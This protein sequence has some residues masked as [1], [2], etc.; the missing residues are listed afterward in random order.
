M[1]DIGQNARL[2]RQT[3]CLIFLLFMI[4]VNVVAI[5]IFN[6]LGVIP[7]LWSPAF[8][9]IISLFTV[10]IPTIH[11]LVS[12]H[13]E[14]RGFSEKKANLIG[15][16]T[17]DTYIKETRIGGISLLFF[18]LIL[19]FVISTAPLILNGLNIASYLF[20][21]PCT[22]LALSPADSGA[23]RIY[24]DIPNGKCIGISDSTLTFDMK[25]E[26]ASLKRNASIDMK[27]GQADE[28][29]QLWEDAIKRNPDDAEALIYLEDYKVQ[30]RGGPYIALVVVASLTGDER[31]V[32]IGREILQGAYTAQK[33]YNN[34]HPDKP[35]FLYIANSG[36]SS[37][38]ASLVAKQVVRI[39]QATVTTDH[40]LVGVIGWPFTEQTLDA[41]YVLASAKI[42]MISPIAIGDNL[43][44]SSLFFFRVVP[45]DNEQAI[46]AA[47]Y[48]KKELHAKRV[49][50]LSTPQDMERKELADDFGKQFRD[51]GGTV[52]SATEY[53][54]DVLNSFSNTVAST[55]ADL[56]YF[57][58]DLNDLSA[59]LESLSTTKKLANV[60]VLTADPLDESSNFSTR[61]KGYQHLHFTL[62][63]TPNEWQWIGTSAATSAFLN[64]Y[65]QDFSSQRPDNGTVLLSYDAMLV[66]LK[67][68]TL[69]E[70]DHTSLTPVNLQHALLKITG[71]LAIQGVTGLLSFN[72]GDPSEKLQIIA[73][74]DASG[75][76]VVDQSGGRYR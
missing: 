42:P 60:Q 29:A 33:L 73:H 1:K 30:R 53:S 6:D 48:A 49:I 16:R 70:L 2:S 67:G 14:E 17:R 63:A 15:S 36:D 9:T 69:I 13:Y 19:L 56:I 12:R 47:Q 75:H 5:W 20:H 54:S 40:P 7:G 31:S 41:Q 64:A 43:T 74:F 3:G 46:F 39:S 8:T 28:A 44:G 32:N 68:F 11:I 35:L 61:L 25:L 27:A 24:L 72:N 10:G 37:A 58:G 57:S 65:Q 62:L 23:I 52:V 50:I 55:H 66:F 76:L 4:F 34:T 71:Y 26:D 45:S 22:S 59:L 51:R 38:D 21:Y 18:L